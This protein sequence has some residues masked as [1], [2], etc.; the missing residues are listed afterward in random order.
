MR[1]H[2][3]F[4]PSDPRSIASDIIIPR[5]CRNKR[6]GTPNNLSAG[7]RVATGSQILIRQPRHCLSMSPLSSLIYDGRGIT[8]R[9]S[10][11]LRVWFSSSCQRLC[12]L[13]TCSRCVHVALCLRSRSN[14]GV[15]GF[16][17]VGG[18]TLR[19]VCAMCFPTFRCA[20]CMFVCFFC[21]RPGFSDA[22]LLTLWQRQ[23]S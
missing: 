6:D 13:F 18:S 1:A 4:P 20:A 9:A 16:Q 5:H 10:A 11:S 2:S 22:L 19:R 3:L 14:V 21:V 12:S 8:A 7:H 15:Q 23:D 17:G